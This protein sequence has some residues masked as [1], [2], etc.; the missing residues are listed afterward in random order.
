[1]RWWALA[2]VRSPARQPSAI[3][4]GDGCIAIVREWQSSSTKVIRPKATR[5]E[6]TKLTG[7]GS[8]DGAESD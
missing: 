4:G 6:R 5:E 1:V 3:G 7:E 2:A 8:D